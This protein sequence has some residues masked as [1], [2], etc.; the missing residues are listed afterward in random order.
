MNDLTNQPTWPGGNRIAIA[1]NVDLEVWSEGNAPSYSVQTSSV[2]P[3]TISHG[4]IA[5]SRYGGTSGVWRVMS[6]LQ[7]HGLPANFAVNAACAHEFPDAVAAIAKAGFDISGHGYTQDQLLAYMSPDE[8]RATIHN[9]LDLLEAASGTRPTGWV[10]PV[11]A[12]T[13]RTFEFL[14]EAGVLWHNEAAESDRPHVI[15]AGGRK[16]VAIPGSDFTDNRVLK[17]APHLLLETYKRTFGYL[18]AHEP[19]AYM[20]LS[21]HAQF[22][23]R[24]LMIAAFDELI[25][26]FKSFPGV[27]FASQ[28]EVARYVMEA[29]IETPSNARRLFEASN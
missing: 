20:G 16:M 24:P 8:E 26:H 15:T 9:C 19:M 22:G 1:I 14:A 10:T 12:H 28:G 4:G 17:T 29:G 23:G 6:M 21:I 11:H 27:W 25:R 13:D 3:G 5:W 18:H 7:R 2:R